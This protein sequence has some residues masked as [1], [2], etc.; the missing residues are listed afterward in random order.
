MKGFRD[1]L[2]RGNLLELA[3]AFI[4]GAAFNDVTK[5]FTAIIMGVISKILGGTPDF[6]GATVVGIN[7]GQFL[8]ALVSFVLTAAVLYFC[9]V[10]PLAM[11][12][13]RFIKKAEEPKP[14][15]TELDLLGQIRD[16]LADKQASGGIIGAH[17][18]VN[19]VQ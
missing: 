13:E 6:S 10:K 4:M 3:V 8:T 16:I 2:M 1:F 15:P 18:P 19:P 11:L 9:I 17:E 5:S 7:V 14:G 12:R